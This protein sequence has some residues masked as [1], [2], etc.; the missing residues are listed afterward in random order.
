MRQQN[1]KLINLFNKLIQNNEIITDTHS[2][3]HPNFKKIEIFS[4]FC[5]NFEV[6]NIYNNELSPK[7]QRQ[8]IEYNHQRQYST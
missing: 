3:V 7:N 8:K 6:L 1:I 5:L 4:K 2:K